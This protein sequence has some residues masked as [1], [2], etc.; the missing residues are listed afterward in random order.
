MRRKRDGARMWEGTDGKG[1]GTMHELNALDEY[2]EVEH[3]T[4]WCSLG[5]GASLEIL[6]RGRQ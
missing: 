1:A 6:G 3:E 5:A 2:R 4:V